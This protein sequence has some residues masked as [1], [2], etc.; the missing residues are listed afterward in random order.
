MNSDSNSMNEIICR[1]M[2]K[3]CKEAYE[4]YCA[5]QKAVDNL[6]DVFDGEFTALEDMEISFKLENENESFE[7]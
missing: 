7:F 5:L 6:R 3:V 2:P 4:V 1:S